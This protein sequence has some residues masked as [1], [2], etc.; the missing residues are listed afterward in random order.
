MINPGQHANIYT[1]QSIVLACT[2][3]PTT[4]SAIIKTSIANNLVLEYAA[5][6][7]AGGATKVYFGI[8][9]SFTG[10]TYR[11]LTQPV[12]PAAFGKYQ[13]Y[14]LL[15]DLYE[16]D[17]DGDREGFLIIPCLWNFSKLYA[18]TDAGTATLTVY[19]AQAVA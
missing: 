5:S 12:N 15:N 3:T 11:P 16:V 2:T 14:Q 7:Y 19:A 4:N 1:T 8:K 13:K 9:P 10:Q 6:S 17:I 18:Y